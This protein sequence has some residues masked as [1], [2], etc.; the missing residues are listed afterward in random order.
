L[1]HHADVRADLLDPA[2]GVDHDP[3]GLDVA[4]DRLA[5]EVDRAAVD[6]PA[7]DGPMMQTTSPLRT[8]SV[9]SRKTCKR[10][11]D[12]SMRSSRRIVG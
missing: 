3:S 4:I 10:P 9:T 1:E 2:L 7:P 6:L 11:K 5:L 8:S 12:L